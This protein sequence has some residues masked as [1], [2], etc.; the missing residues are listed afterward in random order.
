MHRFRTC[1]FALAA[2][3]AVVIPSPAADKDVVSREFQVVQ[4]QVR[5]AR[6]R[7]LP[8]LVRVQ[9]IIEA[10]AGGRKI[11]RT[12][13]GSG[14]VTG[15]QGYVIT[16][17]HVAGKATSCI[18]V[19]ANKEEVPARL[20]GG[21]PWTDIAVIQ[22]DWTKYSGNTITWAVLGD[23]DRMEEGDFVLAMGS[24]F[25]LTRTVTFGIISCRDRSLGV[26]EIEGEQKTGQ[27][28]TWIQI[29]ALINPGNSGGPLVNL[30]GE[31]VGINARGGAGMG[32][33]IPI[34]IVK[35]VSR[36]L[37]AQGKVDRS[38][39][40]MRFQPMEKFKK[41]FL[42]EVATGGVLVADVEEDSPASRAGIRPGDVI[43]S[44]GGTPVHA[45]FEEEIYPIAKRVADQRIGTALAVD[46]VRDKQRMSVSL[47]TEPL[48]KVEGDEVEFKEWGF[49][50]KEITRAYARETRLADARGI[51]ITGSVNG[52]IAE[53]AGFSSGDILRR[54]AGEDVNDLAHFRALYEKINRSDENRV[55]ARILKGGRN[56]R[57]AVVKLESLRKDRAKE[58]SKD[59]PND[60][61]PEG[62]PAEEKAP[63]E[64]RGGT[65]RFSGRS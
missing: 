5:T 44:L 33:A 23:S 30:R 7:V 55:V 57:V 13:F 35:E 58:P 26:M 25:A 15:P 31:V 63:D 49:T 19:M 43:V 38:W 11:S 52:S 65:H 16:N 32:F 45:R 20:I 50:A 9:P 28:N 14:I 42:G 4:E 8:A 51:L 41:R 46:Y 2:L 59:E 18:C 37:I 1:L 34:N 39:L 48:E 54:I 12:G 40:G 10:F 60:K 24:P 3:A 27:F 21:D 22:L 6:D 62:A 53:K 29:D 56:P 17:Y 36:Q 47:T 61:D 64:V